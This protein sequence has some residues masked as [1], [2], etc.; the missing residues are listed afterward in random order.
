MF[1]E[2]PIHGADRAVVGTLVE[3]AGVDFRRGQVNET[4]FA[5]KVEHPQPLFGAQGSFR[6][7]PSACGCTRPLPAGTVNAGAGNPERGTG[8]GVP[9]EKRPLSGD[10]LEIFFET[11]K[12]QS[13]W[14]GQASSWDGLLL[15]IS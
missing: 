5:Q 11:E 8:S 14:P 3:Q 12:V 6:I 7:W 9:S 4:R 13:Q 1:L 2:D 15:S 10:I